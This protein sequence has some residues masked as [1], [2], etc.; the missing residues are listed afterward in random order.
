MEGSQQAEVKR[1]RGQ[2]C[3]GH[4]SSTWVRQI[5]AAHDSL[6]RSNEQN[7]L[8]LFPYLKDV[9]VEGPHLDRKWLKPL[10]DH[11]Y[12]RYGVAFLAAVARFAN[13]A[14]VG[15]QLFWGMISAPTI[16]H[17]MGYLA[18]ESSVFDDRLIY[19]FGNYSSDSNRYSWAIEWEYALA[20]RHQREVSSMIQA[21]ALVKY[22]GMLHG[23]TPS[24]SQVWVEF[25]F[26]Y[27]DSFMIERVMG[28]PVMFT[29]RNCIH[30][31]VDYASRVSLVS[32]ADQWNQAALVRGDLTPKNWADR[33]GV[34]V[35][36]WDY[37]YGK[38]TLDAIAEQFA[39]TG[40]T[41]RNR[42]KAG[43]YVVK[44]VMKKSEMLRIKHSL[45]QG[46]TL[47]EVQEIYQYKN[48]RDLKASYKK[49][50]GEDITSAK[51]LRMRNMMSY[52]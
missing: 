19:R 52:A 16:R 26:P 32:D 2:A 39:L 17:G 50:L 1:I 45:K 13:P 27:D 8:S 41:L 31:G 49:Y 18:Y 22:F 48:L 12:S 47:K 15:P 25:D 4:T 30:I 9:S 24:P 29:G 3:Q 46:V 38:P 35:S 6:G 11:S 36:C 23:E 44:D 34:G 51:R 5:A 20:S 40:P 43:G 14:G 28:V 37:Q 42:L 33:L 7:A 21:A 10:I